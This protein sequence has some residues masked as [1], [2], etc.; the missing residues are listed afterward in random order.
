MD[1]KA[2]FGTLIKLEEDF[3][4]TPARPIRIQCGRTLYEFKPKC[5]P[6]EDV[7]TE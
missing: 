6:Q 2:K 7:D 1:T 4:L 3:L 5:D